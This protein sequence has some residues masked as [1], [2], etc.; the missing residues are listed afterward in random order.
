MKPIYLLI[1]AFIV[2]AAAFFAYQGGE[3]PSQASAD[4]PSDTPLVVEGQPQSE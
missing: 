4:M 3:R 1:A 2:T